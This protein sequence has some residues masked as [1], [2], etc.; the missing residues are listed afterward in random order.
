[1]QLRMGTNGQPFFIFKFRT[2][3]QNADDLK[4]EIAHLNEHAAPGGDPR[5]FKVKQ[6]PRVT[7]MG[8]LLRGSSLDELPQLLNVLKGDMSLIGPRPLILEEDRHVEDWARKRLALK[9]G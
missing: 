9:P 3:V 2:M 1:R 7:T 5:M 4:D 8:R 6:D